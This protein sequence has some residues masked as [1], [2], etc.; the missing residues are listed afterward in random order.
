MLF[1]RLLRKSKS[2]HPGEKKELFRITISRVRDM[3]NW[4]NLDVEKTEILNYAIEVIGKELCYSVATEILYIGKEERS[5][6]YWIPMQFFAPHEI[7]CPLSGINV[8]S[9]TYD[10]GKLRKAIRHVFTDGF[11][12]INHY[13]GTYYPEINLAIIDNGIHHLSAAMVKGEGCAQLQVCSLTDAFSELKTDGA[14]WYIDNQPPTPV[15]EP[16]LAVL[17]ELARIRNELMLPVDVGYLSDRELPIP[18]IFHPLNNYMESYFRSELLEMELAIKKHQIS[19][20]TRQSDK[21]EPD[22][23]VQQLENRCNEIKKQFKEWIDHEG[24]EQ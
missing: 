2:L 17:Y 13:S 6:K 20:L 5:F 8:L 7:N 24:D 23:K 4:A 10:T 9:D 19:I 14:Y 22:S 21:A 11:R 3:L 1:S 16:R 15:L 12:Q 18:D